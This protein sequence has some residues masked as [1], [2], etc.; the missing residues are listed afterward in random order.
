M[1]DEPAGGFNSSPDCGVIVDAA[2]PIDASGE[3]L[4]AAP[5]GV[6]LSCSLGNTD[7]Q[8]DVQ[9]ADAR[10]GLQLDGGG[11]VHSVDSVEKQPLVNNSQMREFSSYCAV[12]C[13]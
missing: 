5:N 8:D 11:I 3:E 4:K 6:G 10:K 13:Y 2:S 1:T 12:E 7:E 9:V